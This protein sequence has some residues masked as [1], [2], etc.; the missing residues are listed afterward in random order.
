MYQIITASEAHQEFIINAQ[1]KMARETE[2]L[3]LDSNTVANGVAAVF[4]DPQLGYYLI[5]KK[6][7]ECV[8]SLLITYEW[9]DWRNGTVWWIQ[10][11]YVDPA[12]RKKGVFKKLYQE[13]KNRV[14]NNEGVVGLRLYVDKTNQSAQK[15]YTKLGMNGN[16]YSLF[17]W[18]KE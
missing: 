14:Q 16:H 7:E 18:M 4:K 12:H 11:V 8:A 2:N 17:E 9:S 3:S 15:V 13:I 1:L 10:S 6:E 5:A